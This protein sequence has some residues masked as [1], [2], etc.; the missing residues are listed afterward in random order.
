MSRPALWAEGERGR[1]DND[2]RNNQ[3]NTNM[4]TNTYR[5]DKVHL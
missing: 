5:N 2:N 1:R 4:N 3:D